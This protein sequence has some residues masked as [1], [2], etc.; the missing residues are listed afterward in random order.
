MRIGDEGQSRTT[1]TF[2]GASA[3]DAKPVRP[4]LPELWCV[5]LTFIATCLAMTQASWLVQ[6][7]VL[8]NGHRA[9][10]IA[11]VLAFSVLLAMVGRFAFCRARR[12]LL[13]ACVGVLAAALCCFMSEARYVASSSEAARATASSCLLDPVEDPKI[14]SS[15][16]S[17]IC[18]LRN[19]DGGSLGKVLVQTDEILDQ[20]RLY[21]VAGSLELLGD[22]SWHRYL[23]MKGCV[24]VVDVHAIISSAPKPFDLVR[25]VR[26]WLLKDIE[27]SSS[28][29]RALVAGVIC[30]RTTELS[31]TDAETAFSLTGLSHLV[32][33]S[34]SHLAYIA[35]LFESVMLALGA[36]VRARSAI[37]VCMMG[38][39]VIFTGCAAS[40]MRSFLMVGCSFLTIALRR[41]PHALSGLALS[42]MVLC[43]CNPKTVWDLGFQLSAASVLF[44]NLFCSYGAWTIERA[45]VRKS[46]S[47]QLSMTL[48]AQWATIP[49]TVPVFGSISVI[50][51][52]AN[53]VV[54]PLMTALLA[55]G[56]VLVPLS[57][58][59]APLRGFAMIPLDALANASIFLADAFSKI[60]FSNIVADSIAPLLPL[61]YL[62]AF[63]VYKFWPTIPRL[64]I[65]IAGVLACICFACHVLRWAFFAPPSITVM[66]VGQ[67]DSIIIR[68]GSASLLVDAG[69]D[70]TALEALVRN[71]VIALDGVVITH[72]DKDHWGGLPAILQRI[73]VKR[74]FIAR[75]A[76]DAMPKE[77]DASAFD[78]IVELERGDSIAVANFKCDVVWPQDSVS[79]EENGDSACLL[80]AYDHDGLSLRCLLT[81]DAE[82]DQERIF[83][84]DVG[85]IDVLKLGH[86][87]SGLSVD[88]D[89]LKAIDP[90]VAIASAGKGN[91]YG[92]PA[93]EC[94]ECVLD[95]G[96]QFYCT[97]DC[98]DICIRPWQGAVKI[99]CSRKP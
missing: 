11:V 93:R 21:R 85:D 18:I 2:V 92:H 36:S 75:G 79:G 29:A 22:G 82:V 91:S 56:L 5:T 76:L 38:I 4:L 24:A 66:D 8:A 31:Q 42:C 89:F 72:W 88:D 64:E 13:R 77:I 14:A 60:P 19:K 80:A 16:I 23:Y 46:L 48:T 37:I 87:G 69:V 63:L 54:G 55:A 39:Y 17:T 53:L 28:P 12:L 61:L 32:A 35:A 20:D 26:I 94:V 44:L 45:G 50:S 34:G 9:F 40:A 43:A 68:E 96:S 7:G 58:L 86:H 83:Q 1:A 52:L 10:I 51:P 95:Y 25:M 59:A 99:R 70:E 57:A 30:G 27:P 84:E 47:Q 81:G 74:L 41:R 65:A 15:S 98:G 62:V 71:N 3:C 90:E 33:V 97:I 67:A 78:E 73:S 6:V 49:L